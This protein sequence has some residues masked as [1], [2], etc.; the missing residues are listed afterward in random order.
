MKT[1]AGTERNHST[2]AAARTDTAAEIIAKAIRERSAASQLISEPELVGLISDLPDAD[3]GNKDVSAIL[4]KLTPNGN[5]L[6]KL[7]GK[8]SSYY[9]SSDY[10]TGVYARILLHKLDGPLQ[11]IAETVREYTCTYRRPVPLA[12]FMQPPFNLEP[13]EALNFLDVM[14]KTEGLDDIAATATSASAVYLYSTLHLETDHAVMLAEWLD[15]G[16]ADNP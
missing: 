2:E 5:D 11:L 12:I 14:K 16:Q 8:E 13:G 1:T 9:Y 6:Q 3:K 7:S 10:M 15:V 4:L